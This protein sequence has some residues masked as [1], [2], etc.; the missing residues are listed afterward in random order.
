MSI[1]VDGVQISLGHATTNRVD[2]EEFILTELLEEIEIP[3]DR[4]STQL[5]EFEERY[6]EAEHR[7]AYRFERDVHGLVHLIAV[8]TYSTDPLADG[9]GI[10]SVDRVAHPITGAGG[11]EI[12]FS[13]VAG[14]RYFYHVVAR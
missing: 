14:E 11:I 4:H 12:A 5:A 10:V 7:V 8:V 1:D 6:P 9:R 3:G 13:E 2:P